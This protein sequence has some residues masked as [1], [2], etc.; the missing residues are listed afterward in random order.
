MRL[1]KLDEL[2]YEST[3]EALTPTPQT[4]RLVL[5][6]LVPR[7]TTRIGDFIVSK[8]KSIFLSIDFVTTSTALQLQQLLLPLLIIVSSPFR[9]KKK[10]FL[11][12]KVFV[13]LSF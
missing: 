9:N 7:G 6:I 11:F 3:T 2:S 5:V 13:E 8:A 10:I 1:T 12:F 4:D